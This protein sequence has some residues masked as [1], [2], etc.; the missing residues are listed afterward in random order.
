V[1]RAAGEQ[2]CRL[3]ELLI[4]A[5]LEAVESEISTVETEFMT[6]MVLPNGETVGQWMMPQLEAI[7]QSG[8]MPPLLP[9]G[10]HIVDGEIA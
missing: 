4:K 1:K 2:P 8:K 9:G 7:Y 10:D 3:K 6:W 5:K